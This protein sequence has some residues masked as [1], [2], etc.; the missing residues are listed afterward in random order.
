MHKIWL[1]RHSMMPQLLSLS[2][3]CLSHSQDLYFRLSHSYFLSVCLSLSLSLSLTLT[4]SLCLSLCVSL[5]LYNRLREWGK[6][7][8]K[9]EWNGFPNVIHDPICLSTVVKRCPSYQLVAGSITNSISFCNCLSPFVTRM[10]FESWLCQA[11]SCTHLN[12]VF[13]LKF[14]KVCGYLKEWLQMVFEPKPCCLFC[15]LSDHYATTTT[16]AVITSNS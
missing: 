11:N 2:L 12:P 16:S 8:N 7:A 15:N 14:W 6:Q 3:L 9:I 10:S 13:P 5:S 1:W 4:F